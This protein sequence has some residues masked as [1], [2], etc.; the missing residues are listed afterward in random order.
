ML[1]RVRGSNRVLA[2]LLVAAGV[3][4]LVMAVL[5]PV[6][7]LPKSKK[8]PLDLNITTVSEGQGSA[9][10]S[11]DPDAQTPLDAVQSNLPIRVQA[12]TTVEEPS[13]GTRMTLQTGQ[14]VARTDVEGDAGLLTGSIDRVTV[15]RATGMPLADPVAQLQAVK[16]SPSVELPRDGLQYVFPVGTQ[17]QSYPYFDLV[18][19]ASTNVDFVEETTIDGLPVYHFTQVVGP[20]DLLRATRDSTMRQGLTR[21]QW[22][23]SE[24]GD[25][26]AN[27]VVLMSRYYRNVRDIYVEPQSGTIVSLNERPHIYYGTNADDQFLTW[28]AYQAEYTED[29]VAQRVADA[30][31]IQQKVAGTWHIG[32]ITLGTPL[33]IAAFLLMGLLGLIL[34]TLGVLLGTGGGRRTAV[35]ADE[36]ALGPEPVFAGYSTGG[37][38]GDTTRTSSVRLNKFD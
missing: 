27:E 15:D 33:L 16:G 35:S 6:Y 28:L 24:A 10:D 29:T 5:L 2:P 22:G 30:R 34:A 32:S 12:H 17:Q 21:E 18:A 13:D 20:V 11:T 23:L 38:D 31:R 19:R 4:L 26:D 7:S 14:T 9:L 25:A 36:A 3:F 1:D 37:L 8:A